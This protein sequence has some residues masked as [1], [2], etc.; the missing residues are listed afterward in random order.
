MITC[1][2]ISFLLLLLSGIAEH[3]KD[4]SSEGKLGS[5][6]WH[7]NHP[8]LIYYT[9]PIVRGWYQVDEQVDEPQETREEWRALWWDVHW[10][11]GSAWERVPRW[12]RKYLAFR[13]GWHLLKFASVNLWAC[14]FAVTFGPLVQLS[15][16][17]HPVPFA[18]L[19]IYLLVRL[20]WSS[21]ETLLRAWP[22]VRSWMRNTYRNLFHTQPTKAMRLLYIFSTLIFVVILS[23][24]FIN[25]SRYVETY[26]AVFIAAACVPVAGFVL[27]CWQ[28]IR[29]YRRHLDERS[30]SNDEERG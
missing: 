20:T 14:A 28:M 4:L 18:G 10:L 5:G 12:I 16:C 8:A 23:Y 29:A 30:E 21:P 11:Q 25:W 1:L 26:G 9:G 7:K 6:Y 19:W 3:L 15:I 22:D 24:L 2:L 27:L 13:D 17:G